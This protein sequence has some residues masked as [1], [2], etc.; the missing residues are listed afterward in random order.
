MAAAKK[1]A[2]AAQ[3]LVTFVHVGDQVF[4]PGDEVPTDVAALITN[5]A[6]WA[7]APDAAVGDLDPS[8]EVA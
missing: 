8:G 1:P 5:P 4:G 3:R 7:P 6:A 2:P